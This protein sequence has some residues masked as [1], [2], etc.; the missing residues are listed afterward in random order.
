VET[1]PTLTA[2]AYRPPTLVH[3]PEATIQP[4]ATSAPPPETRQP[5]TVT[6]PPTPLQTGMEMR[7]VVYCTTNN[8]PLKMDIQ[9][10][11]RDRGPWP[12]VI[13]VHGGGW[14]S[15]SKLDH[16]GDLDVPAL[17][18]AGY[19]AIAVSYRLAPQ[20][21]FPAMIQDVKCA[22]RYLRAHAAE[23]NLDPDRI[24]VRGASAGGH[25]AAMLG[26]TDRSSGWDVGEYLDQSSR[27]QAVI[28][29]FGP[30]S[31]T[32]RSAENL[33]ALAGTSLF[34]DNSFSEHDLRLASPL[35][36]V[37]ADDPPMLILHGDSDAVVNLTQS[38]LFYRALV[39]AG[40]PAELV[41]VQNSG[42]EFEP[43]NGSPI[44]PSRA[45]ITQLMI[46]FL[47]RYLKPLQ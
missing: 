27:V 15:G 41:I 19:T 36:Y 22:V 24:A 37:S 18:E 10:P 32:D 29:M 11:F 43:V 44:S 17:R 5:P 34:G 8:I 39:A 26:V 42:H 25:I 33:L 30:T 7:D 31:L 47:D 20:Y 16:F 35:S 1:Q 28:D 2:T 6:P 9:F 14:I 4:P 12:V 40:V 46:D 3:L 45:E 38:K 21:P 23:Y 13:Y